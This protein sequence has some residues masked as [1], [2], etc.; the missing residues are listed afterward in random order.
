VNEVAKL[1]VLRPLIGSDKQEIMARAREIGTYEISAAD[2]PDCCTLFMPRRPETHARPDDVREAWESF[3]H[4]GMIEDLYRHVE[5]VDFRQ[6]A[7]YK[8]PRQL[9]VRHNELAPAEWWDER[10]RQ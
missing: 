1:P 9:R 2:A 5:Y 3:D 6:C 4:E 10:A 8:P 7:A